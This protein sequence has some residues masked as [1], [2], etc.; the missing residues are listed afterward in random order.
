MKNSTK[1]KSKNVRRKL[2]YG[3][4]L[5]KITE[6]P[7]TKIEKQMTKNGKITKNQIEK[8]RAEKLI[9]PKKS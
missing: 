8:I 3:Q 1:K 7:T 9:N 5:Q 6:S 2:K 4:K